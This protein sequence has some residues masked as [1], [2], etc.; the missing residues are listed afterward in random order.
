MTYDSAGDGRGEPA[1]ATFGTLAPLL[2]ENGF[3]PVPIV[4]GQKRPRPRGWEKGGFAEH[5]QQFADDYTGIITRNTP[6]ID[7]DVS[8]PELVRQIEAIVLDVVDCHERP[9]LARVGMAPRRLL[10]FRTEE[11][12]RKLQTSEYALPTDPTIGGKVKHSKVEILAD[13]Q[14]FV[15][16]AVHPDTGMSYTWN[17]DGDGD[18]LTVTQR[19]LV[20]LDQHQAR[21]IVQRAEVLL[22]Q[23]GRRVSGA[24][25]PAPGPAAAE[26][27][28]SDV[29]AQTISELRSAL[30]ILD[31]GP[32]ETWIAM[33]HALRG[34]GDR[35]RELWLTWSQSSSKYDAAD[36]ARVWASLKP[37]QTGYPA[38]F[39]A[40]QAA[41]WVNPASKVAALPVAAPG[42]AP[43]APAGRGAEPRRPPFSLV[44]IDDLDA[45][46]IPPQEWLWDHYIP[47]RTLTLF[48]AHGGTGK[49]TVALMLAVCTAVGLPL[50]NVP[51]R[52]ARVVFY[53]AE[54]DA[55]TV[56]RRLQQVCRDLQVPAHMLAERLVVL[57][58]TEGE[59]LLFDEPRTTYVDGA[60]V[61]LPPT[62]AT[63]DALRELLKESGAELLIVDN[64]SDTYGGNEVVR[65]EVRQFVRSLV[66]L[67]RG[68]GGAVCL[69]AHIDKGAAK[70]FG[71]GES[72][73]GSTAWHN[74][75]R[76]RLALKRDK[77][78]GDLMLE[79]EK[80]NYGPLREPLRLVWPRGGL[81]QVEAPASG[82]V[83]AIVTDNNTRAVLR[84]IHEFTTSREF[85]S[86]ATSGPANAA[87]VLRNQ[88]SFPQR[89]S[90]TDLHDLLRQAQRKGWIERVVYQKVNRHPGERWQ[91]TASGAEVA[92]IRDFAPVAPVAPVPEIDATDADG[93]TAAPVAPVGAGGCGGSDARRTGAEAE[94][95]E[96]EP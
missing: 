29:S 23:Y 94:A 27:W 76:S 14:Q 78:S 4:P 66:A 21:E 44:P 70:G 59:P 32:R 51:T 37:L 77:A 17:G 28:S 19:D 48:G 30:N 24:P 73:S 8:D 65:K 52:P 72:Y 50:F 81:P 45:A 69:L 80:S 61:V 57:D 43:G 54:D 46:V 34:L 82:T 18:P 38:V 85:V 49:S 39:K 89:L 55:D 56:R 41:G 1:E 83:Q 64:A 15:A 62:T 71:G 3:E 95:A 12:F 25:D 13:G 53:S 88:P 35:G 33:G 47:A 10:V 6:A 58:A 9:P 79:Q 31:A 40:A 91:V 2:A 75:P 90:N 63:Y 5:A 84:L 87:K 11:P 20:T 92:E 96:V 74:S 7:I 86:T 93:A 68:Q 26:D 67:V 16:Y 36:A 60:T 42:A 22:A